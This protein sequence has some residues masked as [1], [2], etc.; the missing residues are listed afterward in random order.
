MPVYTTQCLGCGDAGDLRLS[1]ADYD[2]IQKGAKN[3]VCNKC[4][5]HCQILF[6]P[7]SVQFVMKDGESGGWQSKAMKENA[8]RARHREVMARRERD[9]V[10]KPKLQANYQGIET[11]TWKDA[12]EFAR[13][14]TSKTLGESAAKL[15]AQTYDPLVEGTK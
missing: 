12:R 15:V 5:A 8:W 2:D 13:V 14:E 4:D 7:S 6:D 3:L 10:F 9:H 1:F 11:G